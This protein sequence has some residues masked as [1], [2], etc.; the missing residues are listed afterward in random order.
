M[1]CARN[2][3]TWALLVLVMIAMA[4]PVL[5]LAALPARAGDAE[6]SAGHLETVRRVYEESLAIEQRRLP[7]PGQG[8]FMAPWSE[9]LKALWQKSRENPSPDVPDGP[10]THTYFGRPWLPNWEVE[11]HGFDLVSASAERARVAVRLTVHG[12]KRRCIVSVVKEGG[13]W[14]IA[15]IDYGNGHS[16]VATLKAWGGL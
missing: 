9:D 14:R 13:Q 2:N 12:M 5:S 3:V 4:P 7:R 10:I 15:D 6:A 8:A 11:I 1:R 16:Y